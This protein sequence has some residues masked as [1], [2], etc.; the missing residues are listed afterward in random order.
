LYA[1]LL[2]TTTLLFAGPAWQV[3]TCIVQEPCTGN[4]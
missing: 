3:V 4:V 2:C 1:A